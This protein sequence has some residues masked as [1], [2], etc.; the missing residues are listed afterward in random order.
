MK[1][2]KLKM[3]TTALTNEQS[4]IERDEIFKLNFDYLKKNFRLNQLRNIARKLG[5]KNVNDYKDEITKKRKTCDKNYICSLVLNNAN[6]TLFTKET[7]NEN[8]KIKRIEYYQKVKERLYKDTKHISNDNYDLPCLLFNGN[9]LIKFEGKMR[10]KHIVSYCIYNNIFINDLQRLGEDDGKLDLCH[11]HNCSKNCIEPTHFSLKTKSE[12]NYDDKIRDGK[13]KRGKDGV[14]TKITEDI[15][16]KIKHSVGGEKTQQQR[17]HHF[18]VKLG[19]VQSIDGNYSWSHLPYKNGF[20]KDNKKKRNNNAKRRKKNQEK[21]FT[22]DDFEKAQKKIRD[23]CKDSENIVDKVDSYCWLYQGSLFETGY[24][25]I[26]F[27]GVNQSAH[28]LSWISFNKKKNTNEKLMIRHLCDV[29]N[30]C[31]PKHLQI[32]TR[33]QNSIDA[34]P[35]SQHVKLNE[36]KVKEIRFLLQE[37]N[38]T[39]KQIGEK[40]G[41][42]QNA[43]SEINLRKRWTHVV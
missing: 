10:K 19:I 23:F 43:I 16:L 6:F 40:Y 41:V 15:A 4:P 24:G 39:Q 42:S 5:E 14:F 13:I 8:E 3:E 30:C 26:T 35:Y 29:R 12:N 20:V 34:L 31:N 2:Q 17:A 18:N 11:G 37:G 32:G 1:K 25:Q 27:N 38:L 9:D 21:K 33:R 22:N 7:I 28:V 36:E